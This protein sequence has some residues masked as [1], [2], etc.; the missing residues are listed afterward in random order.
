MSTAEPCWLLPEYVEDMLPPYA[1]AFERLRARMLALFDSHG[2]DLVQPPLVEF[3]ESLDGGSTGALGGDLDLKTVKLVDALSGR[4][5]GV[6]ADITPQAARIDAHLINREGVLRLCYAGPV[7]HARPDSLGNRR[8]PYQIGAELFGYSGIEADLEVLNLLLAAFRLAG[9]EAQ[10]S[11]GHVGLFRALVNAAGAAAIEADLFAALRRKDVPEL[12]QR[13]A[14]L[15]SA[16]AQAILAL[17]EL[18]GGVEVLAR[19]RAVLPKIAGV[20]AALDELERLTAGLPG[21]GIGIDLADLRGYGYH[22]GVVFAGYVGGQAQAV[23]LGGRY[24]GAGSRF[25]RNRAAT[26]FSLDLRRLLDVLPL[27]LPLGGILAP[28]DSDPALAARVAE[29]RAAGE[30]VVMELPGQSAFRHECGCDRVLIRAGS[31]AWRVESLN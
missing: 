22:S 13:C 6:R 14:G 29:L 10:V 30:R 26:G 8:E 5:I 7:L 28:A 23:A 9:V 24:D 17:T 25:G 31:D 4:Q 15:D 20:T 1:A 16:H 12:A 21:A 27:P 18:Y 11:L 19:A 3:L 2:F